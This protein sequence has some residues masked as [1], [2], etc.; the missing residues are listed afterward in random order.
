M[1][2][3][4][5]GLCWQIQVEKQNWYSFPQQLNFYTS[6]TI[7]VNVNPP[8]TPRVVDLVQ[9]LQAVWLGT[10]WDSIIWGASD[11]EFS[12]WHRLSG[13][14]RFLLWVS[15][16]VS[17]WQLHRYVFGCGYF[18]FVPRRTEPVASYLVGIW[19]CS[20]K[21]DRTSSGWSRF[22]IWSSIFASA[23]QQ[24]TRAYLYKLLCGVI[25]I[26]I[27]RYRDSG[28]RVLFWNW[29]TLLGSKF[30]SGTY[31]VIEY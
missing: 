1:E 8:P 5:T 16:V 19:G 2:L 31:R 27:I 30:M 21:F 14:G 24:L 23:P 22:M 28:E 26:I 10:A 29:A 12:H 25:I 9:D 11:S 4:I 3:H 7:T 6:T 20:S 17:V 18:E 13:N 15:I